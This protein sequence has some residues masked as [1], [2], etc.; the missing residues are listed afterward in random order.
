MQA[1]QAEGSQHLRVLVGLAAVGVGLTHQ[2]QTYRVLLG[3]ARGV[4]VPQ[5]VV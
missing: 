4:T 1:V 5:V 2:Q 3:L